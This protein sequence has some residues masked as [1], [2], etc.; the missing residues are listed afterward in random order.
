LLHLS[1]LVSTQRIV[2]THATRIDPESRDHHPDTV[3][4]VRPTSLGTESRPDERAGA[5]GMFHCHAI[6]APG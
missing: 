6:Q 5:L 1:P 2:P 3:E 4:P